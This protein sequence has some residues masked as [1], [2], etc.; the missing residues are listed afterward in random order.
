MRRRGIVLSDN[1][2]GGLTGL[3]APAFQTRSFA[4][5]K[6][7]RNKWAKLQSAMWDWFKDAVKRHAPYDFGLHLGDLIN[8]KG[9]RAGGVGQITTD[10][11]EQVDIGIEPCNHIRLHARKGFE[12]AGVYGT[13]YH[14]TV[15]GDNWD[16]IAAERAGFKQFGAHEWVR[17]NKK[18]TFD[19]KHKVG[20]SSVPHGRHTAIAKD[21]LWN[22]LW[23]ERQ[24]QAQIV[25]RGHAHYH[26]YCGGD[27]WLAAIC[28]SLQ[29]YTK[30]GATQ[31]SGTVDIGFMVFEVDDDGSFA[32]HT[33][34]C[35]LPVF[36]AKVLD[37]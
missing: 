1:H 33:E 35:K 28:P 29:G 13:D 9:K 31:C 30:Y 15:D 6:T 27:G 24:P 12:W 32:W 7:K 18:C 2:G 16:V 34:I 37:L 17:I 19:L 8:G 23:A 22:T 3:T 5:S 14:V 25:L 11:S 36:N 10:M 4:H 20:S 21:K 26:S